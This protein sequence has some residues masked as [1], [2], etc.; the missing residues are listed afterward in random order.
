MTSSPDPYK[1]KGRGNRYVASAHPA[2]LWVREDTLLDLVC[3]FF[4]ERILGPGRHD[5]LRSQL[6]VRD[7]RHDDHARTAR[8]ARLHTLISD[9]E[10]RQ[11]NL[12]TRLEQQDDTGD[13]QTDQEYRQGIQRRFAELAA[14]HRAR[15]QELTQL[16]AAIP[17]HIPNDPDLLTGVPQLPLALGALPEGLQRSLYEVFR[18][19]VCYHRPRHEVT[20]RVTIRAEALPSLTQLVREAADHSGTPSIVGNP[21]EIGSH[22]LG[23]P[24]RIR[25]CAHGSGGHI[26]ISR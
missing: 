18:L 17:G 9:I 24:G 11:K 8:Q 14:A 5:L 2:S 25:T 20:I 13:P 15:T 6:A 19:Q 1:R 10:R 4:A 23:A 16:K 7:G 21:G 12:I 22:V 3:S 26:R